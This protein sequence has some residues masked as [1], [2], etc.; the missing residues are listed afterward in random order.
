MKTK[1]LT[2]P[3]EIKAA[4]E[5]EGEGKLSGY[6][7]TFG[8]IDQGGDIVDAGAFTKTLQ[9][10]GGKFPILADHD[11][12]KQ[13]GWNVSA[14]EDS[15]GL[16]VEGVLDVKNNVL[17]K[18]RFSLAK[19]GLE[20]GV[21]VGLSIGYRIIKAEKDFDNPSVLRLK[22]LKLFEYSLV[23]YPMNTEAMVLGAKNYEML[24]DIDSEVL[25]QIKFLMDNGKTKTEILKALEKA[26]KEKEPNREVV[27]SLEKVSRLFE[28]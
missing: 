20:L 21:K 2:F 4:D 16:L 7:S 5:S 11:P 6:A 3:L 27:H 1:Y 13:I 23:T 12:R 15:H 10:N 26:A 24:Q 22:E 9:E 18:E 25:A 28:K 19:K 17:A 14:K 8:N